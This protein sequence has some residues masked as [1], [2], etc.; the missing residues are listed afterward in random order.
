MHN[1]LLKLKNKIAEH[2]FELL[3]D[4]MNSQMSGLLLSFLITLLAE[5]KREG[6]RFDLWLKNTGKNM[7]ILPLNKIEEFQT[8]RTRSRWRNLTGSGMKHEGVMK[9][10]MD[11]EA[12]YNATCRLCEKIG[13]D[14]YANP[15]AF[16]RSPYGKTGIAGWTR[17]SPFR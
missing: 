17:T 16:P 6:L 4:N 8:F 11:A 3:K 13:T 5:P 2:E 15:A 14:A 9:K 12:R 10:D 7:R 1:L